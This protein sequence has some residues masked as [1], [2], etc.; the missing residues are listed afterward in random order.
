MNCIRFGNAINNTMIINTFNSDNSNIIKTMT[1]S[2][3][4]DNK[5]LKFKPM[6]KKS[7]VVHYTF[8]TAITS[9]NINSFT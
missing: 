4:H 1:T 6:I 3:N 9:S 5:I 2:S 7:I 8:F